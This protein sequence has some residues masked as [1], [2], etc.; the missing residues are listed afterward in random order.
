MISG[1]TIPGMKLTHEVAR[2]VLPKKDLLDTRAGV[3][4]LCSAIAMDPGLGLLSPEAT[5]LAPGEATG[6]DVS[7][8]VADGSRA[9]GA[10]RCSRG[11]S[12]APRATP[13]SS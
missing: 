1:A 13:R 11:R 3:E 5:A 6:R 8:G 2:D 12:R 10:P 4:A 7:A 9:S